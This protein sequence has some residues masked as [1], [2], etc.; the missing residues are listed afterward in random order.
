MASEMYSLIS[1]Q[2]KTDD[3]KSSFNVQSGA[4]NEVLPAR[5]LQP[6]RVHPAHPDAVVSWWSAWPVAG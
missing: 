6:C 4:L 3:F 2:V 5:L 1:N